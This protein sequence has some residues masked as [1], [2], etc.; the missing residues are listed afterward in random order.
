[1]LCQTMRLIFPQRQFRGTLVQQSAGAEL[2]D[3]RQQQDDHKPPEQ[4]Q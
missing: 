4:A 3:D 2:Y 1:M